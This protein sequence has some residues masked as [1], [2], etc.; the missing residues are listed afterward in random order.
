MY[1]HTQ[2]FLLLIFFALA[3]CS[4]SNDLP[5]GSDTRT[6][7]SLVW[8]DKS[9]VQSDDNGISER[10]KMLKDLVENILPQKTESEI[11][12][13]L[14]KSLETAY[15]KSLDKD[16][17]YYLGPERDNFMNI[18]SEWLLIWLDDSGKFK[19]YRVVND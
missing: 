14:G 5:S 10:E 18:D 2:I 9:S 13:L 11:E 15:F 4:Q 12:N 17:I 19:E 6:F 8:Q 3:G 1:K 7:D 16:M